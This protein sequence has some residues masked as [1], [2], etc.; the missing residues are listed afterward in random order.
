MLCAKVAEGN[1]EKVETRSEKTM[2]FADLRGV[3]TLRR[4]KVYLAW[5][6]VPIPI[7]LNEKRP[8]GCEWQATRK[9]DAIQ[10]I[11]TAL[12]YYEWKHE[13]NLG[14]LCGAPSGVVVLDIDLRNGGVEKWEKEVEAHGAPDT[15]TVRTGSGG[16]HL[17]FKY[18]GDA[19]NL[20]TS[21]NALGLGWDI[22]S[23]SGQVLGP[24]SMHPDKKVPYVPVDGFSTASDSFPILPGGSERYDRFA[25]MGMMPHLGEMPR[26]IYDPHGSGRFERSED[27]DAKSEDE[28]RDEE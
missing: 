28:G 5:G 17:Y 24:F 19:V 8:F 7:R 21:T 10:R 27:K 3:D 12:N 1:E 13:L 6:F 23:A 15:F 22:R 16:L 26:W 9:H 2:G 4:A 14:V 11:K 25:Y 20:P 18:T